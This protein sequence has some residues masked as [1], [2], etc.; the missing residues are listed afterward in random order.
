LHTWQLLYSLKKLAQFSFKDL[1]DF[2]LYL[3]H[4]FT[5]SLAP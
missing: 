4:K 5:A 2:S 3:V 1:V